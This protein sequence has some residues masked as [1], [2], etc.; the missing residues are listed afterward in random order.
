MSFKH[1]INIIN[2]MKCRLCGYEWRSNKDPKSCPRC[3]R[4]DW[5][6]KPIKK[7]LDI[8]AIYEEI[9]KH[10]P[11]EEEIEKIADK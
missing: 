6:P 1:F 10:P 5:K 8:R 3:K 9:K 7:Q 4:Y 2:I 11:T